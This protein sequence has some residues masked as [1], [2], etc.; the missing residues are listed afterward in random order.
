MWAVHFRE[1]VDCDESGVVYDSGG[2]RSGS[3]RIVRSQLPRGM[4]AVRL[5][6]P[7]AS[8][9]SPA[10]LSRPGSLG[11][12]V[13]GPFCSEQFAGWWNEN[14]FTGATFENPWRTTTKHNVALEVVD[15]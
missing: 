15:G 3:V 1:P 7:R 8:W 14:R 5:E 12:T 13:S 4:F 11:R 10:L 6:I 2:V 9:M